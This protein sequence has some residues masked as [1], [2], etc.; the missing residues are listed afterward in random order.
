[1][2]FTFPKLNFTYR[3]SFIS[4]NHTI[5]VVSGTE[6]RETLAESFSDV[7]AD[8][9]AIQDAGR[10]DIDGKRVPIEFFLGGDYKVT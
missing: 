8:V 6:S 1:M 7:F 10:I 2:T 4:G 3:F 9:N 5:A